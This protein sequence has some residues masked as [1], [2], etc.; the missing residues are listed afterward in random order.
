LAS[1]EEEIIYCRFEEHIYLDSIM[2][3]IRSIFYLQ[4]RQCFAKL[5]KPYEPGNFHVRFYGREY[6][7][8]SY[9]NRGEQAIEQGDSESSEAWFDQAANYWKQAIALAPNNYIEAQNWLKI[10]GRIRE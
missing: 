2:Q 8:R 3:Y 6:F 9:P 10:T 1:I 7:L 5:F 4:R